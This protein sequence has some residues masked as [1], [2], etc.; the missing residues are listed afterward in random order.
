MVSGLNRWRS[1]ILLYL[2][3]ENTLKHYFVF[4]WHIYYSWDPSFLLLLLSLWVSA[5]TCC[6]VCLKWHL[7]VFIFTVKSLRF[8]SHLII[9]NVLKIIAMFVFH[10]C[11]FVFCK[12]V[13]FSFYFFKHIHIYRPSAHFFWH[14]LY[15][16]GRIIPE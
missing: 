12:T 4:L 8:Q 15:I 7:H 16:C 1:L 10:P 13:T 2:L 14:L 5:N 3:C 6:K 11:C 9:L